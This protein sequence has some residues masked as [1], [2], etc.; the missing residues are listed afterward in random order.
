MPGASR[1]CKEA[2]L[3]SSG[4]VAFGRFWCWFESPEENGGGRIDAAASED[5]LLLSAFRLHLRRL[6][7]L[8]PEGYLIV[9]EGST[10]PLETSVTLTNPHEDG[11]N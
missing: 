6:P 7:D 5:G 2:L 1:S 3:T 10:L 11:W 8:G 4:G 9:F